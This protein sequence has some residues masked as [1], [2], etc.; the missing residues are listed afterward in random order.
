VLDDA[1]GR[2]GLRVNRVE[3]KAIDPP[4]SIKDAMEKQMRAERDR[5]T[6]LSAEGQRQ[7]QILTAEGDKQGAIL[8]AEGQRAAAILAAQGQ[9]SAIEQVFQAVHRNDPDPKVLAYQ[10]LQMLPQLASGDSNTFWVIPSEFTAALD[11][12]TRA[13]SQTLP[14]SPSAADGRV[15]E[16]LPSSAAQDLAQ[17]ADAVDEALTAAAQAERSPAVLAPTVGHNGSSSGHSDTK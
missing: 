1:T 11:G 2:W 7:S 12:V 14:R 6:V 17:A 9:S 10:Y 5:A 4:K 16:R 3:I 13:F 8:R 15:A